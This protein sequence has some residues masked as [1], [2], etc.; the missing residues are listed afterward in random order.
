MTGERGGA[1]VATPANR[2][3]D[4]RHR[5]DRAAVLHAQGLAEALGGNRSG[6][7]WLAR[8]PAHDDRKASLSLRDGERGVLVKCHASC[9]REAVIAALRE[10]GLWSAPSTR[11][12]SAASRRTEHVVRDAA[13][14]PVAVHVRLD[15][16]GGK[17]V[18]WQRPDGTRGL[19]GL[20]LPDLPLYGCERLATA[21]GAPVVLTEGEK[22]AD[23]LH[24][25]G[26]LAVGTVTGASSTPNEDVLRVLA[27][28]EVVLWPDHDQPGRTH[29]QRIARRLRL[30]ADERGQPV[31]ARTLAWPGARDE[32]DDAADYVARGG[33]RE[34][35]EQ[36][37]AAASAPPP[38][39]S[40]GERAQPSQA[41]VLLD[42]LDDL[43]LSHTAD[44]EPYATL[45]RDGHRETHAMRTRAMRD[46]A[47]HRYYTQ[48]RRP[49]RGESLKEAFEVLEARARYE[50]AEHPVWLRVAERDGALYLDLGDPTWRAV[51]V[52][53]EGWRIVAEPPVRFRRAATTLALPEPARH[54]SLEP[55]RRLVRVADDDLHQL[56]GWLLAALR[57]RGPYPVLTLGGEPGAA[58]TSTARTARSLVD[59]CVAPVRSE[60]REP[61]DLIAA[62]RGGH[63][64]ALDN[65][66]HVSPWLSDALCRLATGGG[67]SA[68]E[69]FT[70]LDEVVVDV[71]RPVI[72]T[73]IEDVC[74]R[75]DLADRAL[76]VVLPA[77]PETA[78]RPE[79]ELQSEWD[80]GR[81]I[82]L[83]AL[84]DAMARGLRE[85]P[86][87]RLD[88][89]PRM[90]DYATW[91]AACEPALGVEPGTMVRAYT[92]ARQS[93][94]ASTIES[95]PVAATLVR[96]IA[97]AR[98][99]EGTT[100]ELHAL[101]GGQV[102]E[103]T[104]HDRRR[105]PETPQSLTGALRRLAPA[106]RASGVVV[107]ALPRTA[108]KRLVRVSY[109]PPASMEGEESSRSSCPSPAAPDLGVSD[110]ELDDER[111]ELSSRSSSLY[112][113]PDAA[114]DEYDDDDDLD[115]PW[116]GEV[117]S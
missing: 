48:H 105:W 107:E 5:D 72:V 51:E 117:A 66:S 115:A 46:Y 60:P 73:A 12:S 26:V 93:V 78:R 68:R 110:D 108:R 31:V 29:M 30:I 3:P 84:L 116:D 13:G 1:G 103:D 54:G 101:L 44:G 80:R 58:K 69:L 42:M 76:V 39:G 50:G 36:L 99:W 94:T 40:S 90:A 20:R 97:H 14:T 75:S 113:A 27:G 35:L 85:I 96:W 111:R 104:R 49:L 17:K 34:E 52:T 62:A 23:A 82:V 11:A 33:T 10:R 28:R 47:R 19:G 64:V 7:G 102:P 77:M 16:P 37:I 65:L 67:Y 112:P 81:P 106:L 91:L 6:D 88:H 45:T 57:P 25:I 53:A 92:R 43:E 32:G 95:S 18:W 22:A 86:D 63:V 55:L 59:P 56:I 38:A 100:S 74:T 89:L 83:G 41:S 109:S 24:A 4:E 114:G 98:R 8:C 70:D 9:A 15:R 87:V 21:P 61:R 71:Q 2:R 79:R